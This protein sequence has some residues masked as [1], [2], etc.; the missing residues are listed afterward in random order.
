MV[1]KTGSYAKVLKELTESGISENQFQWYALM[2]GA[3]AKGVSA[4]SRVFMNIFSE[5]LN[6]GEPLPGSVVAALT[7][8]AMDSEEKL[9]NA[10]GDLFAMPDSS[11]DKK[12]RLGVLSDL[13]Y[14][15]SLGLSI[16]AQSGK[17]EKITDKE[18][19]KDLNTLSEI[20]RVDTEDELEEED[21][22]SVL[23]FM[24]DTASK[25]YQIYSK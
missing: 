8:L 3:M 2:I 14:G 25:N 12:I 6:A 5:I 11:V 4:G 17:P 23:E 20:S 19:L 22:D 13:A 21:L 10:D 1:I 7:N 16:S 9:S 18:L 15:L 24:I